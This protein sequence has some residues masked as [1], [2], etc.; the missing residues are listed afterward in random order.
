M[1]DTH[2]H[3]LTG[4]AEKECH[5]SYTSIVQTATAGRE[6]ILTVLA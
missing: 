3:A 5:S 4:P 1:S 6:A 2:T